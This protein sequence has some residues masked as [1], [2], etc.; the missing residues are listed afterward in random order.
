[1]KICPLCNYHA[2]QISNFCVI[3]GAK[4]INKRDPNECPFCHMYSSDTDK[5]CQEC[6]KPLLKDL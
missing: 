5:F 3:C 4:L 6:G 1:M 2:S